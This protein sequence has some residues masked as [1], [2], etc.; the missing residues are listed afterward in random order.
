MLGFVVTEVAFRAIRVEQHLAR[1]TAFTNEPC[2][3]HAN[4]IDQQL[5][6][7]GHGPRINCQDISR[8]EKAL[9]IRIRRRSWWDR[10]QI[11]RIEAGA[12]RQIGERVTERL[13]QRNAGIVDVEVRPEIAAEPHDVIDSVLPQQRVIQAVTFGNRQFRDGDGFIHCRCN[14][15]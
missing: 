10:Q 7:I 8:G 14:P 6:E 2:V 4:D 3:L 12:I 5:P 13:E 1:T 15:L 9:A 11:D